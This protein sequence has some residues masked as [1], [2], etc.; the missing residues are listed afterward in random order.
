MRSGAVIL[1]ISV[2][3][4]LLALAGYLYILADDN[5]GRHYRKS[6]DL[7]RQT[8]VL[9][10]G[11][12][13]ELTRVKSN[14]LADFDSLT[15][16]IPRMARLKERLSE[17]AQRIPGLPD[18]LAGEINA[19]LSALE[20]HEER[21]ERFKTGYAVV[22]NSTRYFP[23]AAASV[24]RQAEESGDAVLARDMSRLVRDVTMHLATPTDTARVRLTAEIAKLRRATVR[25]APF[26]ANASENMLS[27]AEVLVDK[28]GPTEEL[29]AR[30][31]SDEL[32]RFADRLAGNLEFEFGRTTL[33]ATYYE[34]G[35]FAV[36]GLLVVFWVVL[37]LQQRMRGGPGTARPTA[38]GFTPVAMQ[39]NTNGAADPAQ[40]GPAQAE[41]PPS[42][43]APPPI[44][45]AA[46]R[47]PETVLQNGFV[48]ECVAGVLA[49]SAEE[50]ADR[51]E[52][53]RKTHQRIHETLHNGGSASGTAAD[54]GLEEDV[55]S[56]SAIA[57]SVRQK[58]NGIAD[59]A[60]RLETFSKTRPDPASR[61]MIDV[62]DCIESVTAAA[63]RR[64]H[65]TILK[66][67]GDLPRIVA[68]GTDFQLL[69][70]ELVENSM[71]AVDELAEKKGIIKIDSAHDDEEIQIT[72]IDNGVG[73]A[74]DRRRSIF[75]PFYTSRDGAMGIGLAFAGHLVGKYD[76]TIKINSLP[77][78]GTVARIT[79][80]AAGSP[81]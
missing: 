25:H 51:M 2:S 4:V 47:D 62:N 65:A 21:I 6:I 50:V 7:V 57:A 77:G 60:K 19:Y 8:Q 56:I 15:A 69:L 20:A 43:A 9:S 11:W 55:D 16:F 79:L 76:G 53:L 13:M 14:P 44:V 54:P 45:L 42:A 67:L 27:H 68:C 10:G 23:L 46:P 49:S 73:I 59:I 72:V 17:G 80:P 30:V 39:P 41:R 32:S 26:L 22:R 40:P 48:V 63:S 75:K 36:L 74:P 5:S 78:Q 18:R 64:T 31:T 52:Y 58:M 24:Q 38:A 29:Y 81:S 34:R 37:A 70:G 28:Q 12:S 1:G 71:R 61:D 33:L 66:N 3:V 35:A